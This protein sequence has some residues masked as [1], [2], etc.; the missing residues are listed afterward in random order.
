[1]AGYRGNI[2][3][4]YPGQDLDEVGGDGHTE[5]ILHFQYKVQFTATEKMCSVSVFVLEG[6]QS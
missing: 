4:T 2:F 1:M 6:A 3:G 5:Y